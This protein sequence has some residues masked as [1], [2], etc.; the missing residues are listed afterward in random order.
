MDERLSTESDETAGEGLSRRGLLRRLGGAAAAGAGLAVGAAALGASPAAAHDPDDVALGTTNTTTGA[1]TITSSGGNGVEGISTST[2]GSAVGLYGRRGGTRPAIAINS[3]A[4]VLGENAGGQGVRGVSDSG[5]G[6]TGM[7]DSATGVAGSSNSNS[8]VFGQSQTG[9]GVAAFGG[10]APLLLGLSVTP[11]APTTGVH[12]QGEIYVDSTG[13]I[14]QCVANGD[15]ATATHPVFMRIGLNPI[16]PLR[17]VGTGAGQG[18]GLNA[19]GNHTIAGGA[20]LT[21]K[22]AGT[23][24][25]PVS[26]PSP[27]PIQASAVVF[28]L[29]A[30]QATSTTDPIAITIY[31]ADV[32]TAPAAYSLYARQTA[33]SSEV[34]AK[35][36]VGGA[37]AGKVKIFNREPDPIDVYVDVTGFYS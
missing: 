32:A 12:Q 11:G 13:A 24:D 14:F 17:L 3:I 2:L 33:A 16:S 26:Q 18:G 6:V 27:V 35:L 7:S 9:V 36:G 25:P 29:L 10:T 4:G 37:N 34:T 20:T 28:T 15:F 19:Y 23:L 1:T 30:I 5:N 31:P 8:G 21:V 22:L